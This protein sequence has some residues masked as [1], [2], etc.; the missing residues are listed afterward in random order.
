MSSRSFPCARGLAPAPKGP[1]LILAVF[2]MFFFCLSFQAFGQE[3]TIV[4]T[5]TD[6]A[7]SVVPNVAITITHIETSETRS[8]VTNDTGQYVAPGLGIGHYNVGAKLKGS[9]PNKRM[10]SF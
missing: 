1:S 5:V 4:G 8:S 3:A 7:G 10:A 6:P 2:C 9:K